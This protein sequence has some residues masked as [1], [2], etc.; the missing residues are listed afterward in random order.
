MDFAGAVNLFAVLL[1]MRTIIKDRKVL[2]GFSL[3]VSFLTCVASV[4]SRDWFI[5]TG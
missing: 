4:R 1:L 2:K 5:S 3:T